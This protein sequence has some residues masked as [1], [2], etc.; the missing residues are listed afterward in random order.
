MK[1]TDLYVQ[2]INGKV[3]PYYGP[4]FKYEATVTRIMTPTIRPFTDEE[5]KRATVR[6]QVNKVYS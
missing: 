1:S 2:L 4:E 3:Q 6:A 5:R